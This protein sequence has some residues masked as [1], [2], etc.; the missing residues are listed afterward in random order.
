MPCHGIEN[1]EPLCQ[2]IPGA[3]IDR[4]IGDIFLEM[5]NPVTLDVALTVRRS[6]RHVWMKLIAFAYSTLTGLDMKRNWRSV[7]T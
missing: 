4:V 2:R 5:V 7:D 1:A 6:S 3:E